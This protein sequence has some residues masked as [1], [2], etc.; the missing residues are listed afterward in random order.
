M[1]AK[2]IEWKTIFGSMHGRTSEEIAKISAYFLGPGLIFGLTVSNIVGGLSL[3]ESGQALTIL[4]LRTEISREG[5][6]IPK[7]GFALIF[8][9]VESEYRI[10]L[11]YKPSRIWTSLDEQVAHAN[12]SRL[13]LDDHGISGK[14]P[15]LG[16][17]SPVTVVVEGPLGNEILVP[18]RTQKTDDLRLRSKRSDSILSSILFACV[19]AFGLSAALGLPP[20]GGKER[21]A[22]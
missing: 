11:I 21:T 10:P 9:P 15:F 20:V 22:G 13:M 1:I 19:F 6:V 14:S 18:G 2:M 7:S 5:N 12:K 4:E 16:V 17:K 3:I 8:E